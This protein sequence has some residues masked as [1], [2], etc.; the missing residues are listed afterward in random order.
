MIALWRVE[1]GAR[2]F[3]SHMS[4]YVARTICSAL[5]D[6]VAFFLICDG[7][8]NLSQLHVLVQEL[9][10]NEITPSHA[11]GVQGVGCLRRQNRRFKR[12]HF[13]SFSLHF[14]NGPGWCFPAAL[15]AGLRV[16]IFIL[17]I[18]NRTVP[19]WLRF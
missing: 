4:Q 13:F 11:K 8:T 19:P 6:G 16:A 12:M 2:V 9:K 14:C 1:H 15:D 17:P 3:I 5:M 7:A 10:K 18:T